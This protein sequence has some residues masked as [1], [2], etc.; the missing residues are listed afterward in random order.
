MNYTNVVYAAS[1][2]AP[3]NCKYVFRPLKLAT[4]KNRDGQKH[5]RNVKFYSVYHELKVGM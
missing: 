3:V 1:G 5:K 4:Q 2:V